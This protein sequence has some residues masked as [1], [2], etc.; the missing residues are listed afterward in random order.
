VTN[1]DDM[2]RIWSH[3]YAKENLNCPS[4]DHAVLHYCV[5]LYCCTAVLLCS[6]RL[7]ALVLCTCA[8]H[9]CYALVLCSYAMHD[10]LLCNIC[11]ALPDIGPADGGPP[12]PA[13]E[14]SQGR[15]GLL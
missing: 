11:P 14:Q 2:E 3:I 15:G 12:E 6:T 13:Q 7:N 8:M 4:E 5:L 9:L 10:V 1:W